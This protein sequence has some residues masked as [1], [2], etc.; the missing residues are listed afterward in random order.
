MYTL[1]EN[2]RD[3]SE[4]L[5]IWLDSLIRIK[6][7]DN[8]EAELD[9]QIENLT[10]SI[11]CKHHVLTE[12][13]ELGFDANVINFM[14][15]EREQEIQE[16]QER[17][18]EL[19]KK[20]KGIM[21]ELP[22]YITLADDGVLI[23]TGQSNSILLRNIN[24]ESIYPRHTGYLKNK[25]LFN[26]I[27]DNYELVSCEYYPMSIDQEYMG[28]KKFGSKESCI[29]TFKENSWHFSDSFT[30]YE[31][32]FRDP[33]G[34]D[35]T[36]E[37]IFRRK[38]NSLCESGV[39]GYLTSLELFKDVEWSKSLIH[40][41]HT[42]NGKFYF[43][44][45]GQTDINENPERWVTYTNASDEMNKF[46]GK[47]VFLFND[48]HYDLMLRLLLSCESEVTIIDEEDVMASNLI[49]NLNGA[50]KVSLQ[51]SVFSNINY[52]LEEL[53]FGEFV[54]I[55][56]DI[57]KHIKDSKIKRYSLKGMSSGIIS[58]KVKRIYRIWD[59]SIPEMLSV[60]K[61][62]KKLYEEPIHTM[63]VRL[64]NVDENM[65][66]INDNAEENKNIYFLSFSKKS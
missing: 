7:S 10:K 51:T 4:T 66:I 30:F 32:E 36:V 33:T 41:I 54:E 23:F 47:K 62:Y 1:V 55:V 18:L 43:K 60:V 63:E 50:I 20:Y 42:Y 21:D 19:Y 65:S 22:D 9:I 49:S 52:D 14:L 16:E 35:H 3:I 25:E 11:T 13:N 46:K 15:K 17:K 59:E 6:L 40:N 58:E 37:L 26:L 56:P 53:I 29:Q 5:K 12:N 24:D 2:S 27:L 31:S 61:S 8:Q 28:S 48:S 39:Q 45:D 38:P 44:Y 34:P 64:C 57:R